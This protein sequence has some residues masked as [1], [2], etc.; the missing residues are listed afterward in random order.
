[1]FVQ[2][3][4]GLRIPDPDLRDYLPVEGREVVD[5]PYWRRRIADQDVIVTTGANEKPVVANRSAK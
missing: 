1:M 3:E 5:S 4:P 2:P